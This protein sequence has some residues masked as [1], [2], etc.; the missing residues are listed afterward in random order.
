MSAEA[1]SGLLEQVQGI[2]S[3]YQTPRASIKALQ[4]HTT[5]YKIALAAIRDFLTR[6]KEIHWY[7][8]KTGKRVHQEAY[9][10]GEERLEG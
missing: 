2:S 6:H 9:Y 3:K 8:N 5:S 7:I 10:E 1:T 4:K